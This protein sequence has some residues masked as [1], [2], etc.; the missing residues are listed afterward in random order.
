MEE[1]NQECDRWW[2][3]TGRGTWEPQDR[4]DCHLSAGLLLSWKN[5]HVTW[6][7]F[8]CLPYNP[9][10]CILGINMSYFC[11][12]PRSFQMGKLSCMKSDFLDLPRTEV[13]GCTTGAD[14]SSRRSKAIVQLNGPKG[15]EASGWVSYLFPVSQACYVYIF[16]P[17]TY[18]L[19]SGGNSF[20]IALTQ[21]LVYDVTTHLSVLLHLPSSLDV[22]S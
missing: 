20:G 4:L 8:R 18:T 21:P 17:R 6:E 11:L 16:I 7:I 12:P 22:S 3:W 14:F 1:H 5:P 19:L 2:S 10:S 15:R 13:L 9:G